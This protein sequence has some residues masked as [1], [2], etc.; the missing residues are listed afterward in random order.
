MEVVAQISPPGDWKQP[1]LLAAVRGAEI[2]TFGWPI[3]LTLQSDDYRPRPTSDGVEAEVSVAKSLVSG[4]PSYD[5]WKLFSDGRFYT[6]ISLFEDQHAADPTIWWETRIQR[7]TEALLFLLRLY[8][9]L[10][11][12]DTDQ[13]SVHV[14]HAGLSGRTLRAIDRSRATL[15]RPTAENISEAEFTTTVA[16]LE[17]DFVEYVKQIVQPLF[18]LFEFFEV[19]DATWRRS[20][21]RS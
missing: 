10:E 1:I 7:V 8:R 6:L 16:H 4:R 12:S 13:L 14:R 18:I 21:S 9:R 19:G 15:P 20:S 5:L 3:G 17:S 11:A 2:H